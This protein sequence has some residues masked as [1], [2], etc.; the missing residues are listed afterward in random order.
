[1]VMVSKDGHIHEKYVERC[2][3]GAGRGEIMRGKHKSYMEL[4]R[5]G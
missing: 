5:L 4:D 1:M 2:G 3:S